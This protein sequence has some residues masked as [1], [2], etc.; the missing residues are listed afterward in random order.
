MT[1]FAVHDLQEVTAE[2]AALDRR[3]QDASQTTLVDELRADLEELRASKK[4]LEWQVLVLK[5][6]A[7][8]LTPPDEIETSQDADEWLA[9]AGV[10]HHQQGCSCRHCL[11]AR[12]LLA[13]SMQFAHERLT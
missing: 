4:D 13:Y 10:N 9:W 7:G 1:A 3:L 6:K 11:E 5:A 8:E 12:G 2:I